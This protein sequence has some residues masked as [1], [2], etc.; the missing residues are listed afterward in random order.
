MTYDEDFFISGLPERSVLYISVNVAP[1]H[2]MR[3]AVEV[4]DPVPDLDLNRIIRILG[5]SSRRYF[6]ASVIDGTHQA[7]PEDLTG[8]RGVIVGCSAHSANLAAS[9]LAPWQERVI[10]FI[11]RAVK[12]F[13][14]PFL[15]ICGGGQLGLH[16]LGGE[17]GPNPIGV[18]FNPERERSLVIRTTKV[19][20]TQAGCN[21]PLFEGCPPHFGMT[22]IHADYLK[23][24]PPDKGFVVLANSQDIPNQAIGY[25]DRVRLL[26]LHPEVGRGFLN[27]TAET[28]V[29]T[30]GFSPLPR[31]VLRE[32]FA[33][34]C[35]DPQ[36]NY[37]I[38]KNFLTHFC[39]REWPHQHG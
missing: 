33:N 32:T 19:E 18:G 2:P 39:A 35:P 11:Q 1:D 31:D 37:L 4:T 25:G 27:D 38:L 23:S 20:L 21:D 14:L 5:S 34:I 13:G 24:A 29:S 10:A 17:V 3:P 22:A 8:F 30:G 36:S 6:A 26:G 28:I 7:L 12:D 9:S 16:A 15:G